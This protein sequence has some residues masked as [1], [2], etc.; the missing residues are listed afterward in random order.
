MNWVCQFVR[1]K[2]DRS[3]GFVGAPVGVSK[4]DSRFRLQVELGIRQPV[5]KEN[6]ASK[7]RII[8]GLGQLDV[9]LQKQ[10][11]GRNLVSN[12]SPNVALSFLKIRHDHQE[13][14]IA[15]SQRPGNWDR[16][17]VEDSECLQ[18]HPISARS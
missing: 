6:V 2:D 7:L 12:R 1:L 17:M 10:T 14:R 3:D 16:L 8:G 13:R 18:K 5:E 15:F 11:V 9:A 4:A